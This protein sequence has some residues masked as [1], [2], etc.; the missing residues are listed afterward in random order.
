MNKLESL[1]FF[2]R[3]SKK[4]LKEYRDYQS[5]GFFNPAPSVLMS[6][7]VKKFGDSATLMQ[8]Q[9][10][11][12]QSAGFKNWEELI[13]A[14]IDELE[15][16]KEDVKF[17][18]DSVI[19]N[20]DKGFIAGNKDLF[21]FED[22]EAAFNEEDFDADPSIEIKPLKEFS[23]KEQKEILNSQPFERDQ[24]SE[25]ECLHCGRRFLFEEVN[26]ERTSKFDYIVCKYY[27]ESCDG[28]LIDLINV[29]ELD[30]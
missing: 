15:M 1:D 6:E 24:K 9:H 3:K 27:P 25:V 17:D 29:S 19:I 10:V 23:D 4:L 2:K 21:F 30:D 5:C 7:I 18:E 28:T 12:A 14:D 20:T 22:S 8:I 16:A 11:V 26:V 13:Q